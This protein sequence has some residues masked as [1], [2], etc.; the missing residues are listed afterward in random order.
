VKK[1]TVVMILIL[2]GVSAMVVA[3]EKG[4]G[5]SDDSTYYICG[6]GTACSCTISKEPG[7]CKCGKKPLKK[8]NLVSIEGGYGLF[9]FCGE[10]CDCKL[11]PKDPS[12]CTCGTSVRKLSL[13]GKH[14]CACGEGC[15][16]NTISDKPGNCKCGKPLKQVI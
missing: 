12:K 14:I 9:C 8:A 11:D 3:A 13:K 10:N 15:K 1:I 4:V 7:L 6:C 2:F 5:Q 16:C